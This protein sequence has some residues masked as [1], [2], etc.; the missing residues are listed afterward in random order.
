MVEKK[1]EI[2]IIR[3]KVINYTFLDTEP[4]VIGRE[5][6]NDNVNKV[7]SNIEKDIIKTRSID[8]KKSKVRRNNRIVRG[9]IQQS[10]SSVYE[11]LEFSVLGPS[12]CC[13]YIYRKSFQHRIS[14][15]LQLKIDDQSGRL[16]I[17]S[18]VNNQ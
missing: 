9:Q 18:S 7:N 5:S 16:D 12:P 14:D 1:K 4:I 6:K 13:G 2:K 17:L 10:H 3:E 11:L 8:S 15:S